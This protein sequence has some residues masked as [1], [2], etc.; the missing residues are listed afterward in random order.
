[1][2]LGLLAMLALWLFDLTV[3]DVLFLRADGFVLRTRHVAAAPFTAKVSAMHVEKGQHVEQGARMVEMHSPEF[4]RDMAQLSVRVAD[5]EIRLAELQSKAT[6]LQEILPV[7]RKR[8]RTAR[9]VIEI[10][11]SEKGK[12][13]VTSLRMAA[14][15]KD[16]VD[17]V[18]EMRQISSE[19]ASITAR[20]EHL[21]GALD[22]AKQ[23]LEATRALY[24]DGA[25]DASVTGTVVDVRAAVG[26]IVKEGDPVVEVLT[27]PTYVLAYATPGALYE[28]RPG[29]AVLVRYG[30]RTMTGVVTERLPVSGE[31]PPEFQRAFRPRERAQMF[32]VALESMPE[33]P[34]VLTKVQVLSRDSIRARV[35]EA[36]AQVRLG[37]DYLERAWSLATGR[38]TDPT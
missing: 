16:E 33:P 25:L 14:A 5:L 17:A 21:H 34:P 23:A 4:T 11:E 15:L 2:Y 38:E 32:R 19:H 37:K 6:V 12:P 30:V 18:A 35:V 3:G 36:L 27:G 26:G 13:H 22:R 29:D 31:L 28:I 8:A 10:F 1:M 20:L 9:E 24:A 7:A